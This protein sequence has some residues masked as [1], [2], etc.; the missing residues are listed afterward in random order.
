MNSQRNRSET[1]FHNLLD[2][3]GILMSGYCY[4]NL[5]PKLLIFIGCTSLTAISYG[6]RRGDEELKVPDPEAITLDTT[7]GVAIRSSYYP[8]GFIESAGDKKGKPKVE[9]KPGKEVVPI[10]MLHGWGGRRRDFDELASTLQKRGHAVIVPDLRGHGDS[11]TVLLANGETK[12]IDPDR[13]RSTDMAGMLYDVEAAK[14][15]FLEMNNKGEV[16][17]EMLCVIGADVGAIVAVNWAAYDWSRRQLPAFKQGQ[18][19][20]ALVLVSPKASHKGFSLQK[21]LSHPIIQNSM[22]IMLIVGEGDRT[23]KSAAKSIHTRLEKLRDADADIK[24]KDLFYFGR[25][26]TLQGTQLINVPGLPFRKN[27]ALFI[28]LRLVRKANT[29]SWSERKSPLTGN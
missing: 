21:S 15:F 13:M 20:K 7:D 18:Y 10:I 14:K 26:T 16:N 28:D 2:N 27:I 24:D 29:F 12:E 22:S 8:G 6:Q 11:K 9:K 5:V 1:L 4:R 3:P 25:D 17:I 23:A 19:V